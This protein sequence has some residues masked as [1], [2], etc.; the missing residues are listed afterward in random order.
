VRRNASLDPQASPASARSKILVIKPSALG[1]V[2]QALPV[3][4]SLRRN[5]PE[6][7]IDWV[8]ND[9]YADLLRGHPAIRRLVLYPRSRWT[10][11]AAL[12]EMRR[13][14]QSLAFE[15]YD[16]VIDLQGLLRSGLMA[17]ASGC[18][19]RLGLQSAREGSRW[20]YTES[21]QDHQEHAAE[22]YLQAIRH[23]GLEPHPLAFDLPVPPLPADPRLQPK[24]YVVL[25]PYSRWTTKLWPYRRYQE[26]VDQWP[27]VTLAVVGNGPW[28]PLRSPQVV[29]LRGLLGLREL[30]SVLAH[31]RAAISTDSGPAH[32][33]AAFDV[34]TVVLFGATDPRKTR[35][36][37]RRVHALQAEVV[38]PCL[39]CLRRAC[40]WDHPMACM[41]L[42]QPD[43][44][45]KLIL[46]LESRM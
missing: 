15:G 7:E 25:H 39:P 28:F 1:D 41:E 3:A 22:R 42:I 12:P 36:Q 10:S 31:A 9:S 8:I 19:R 40:R 11:L 24:A 35:P 20:F 33:A 2:V 17:W 21:I 5:W 46:Y 23:L 37:G 45:K 29:D 13:W 43:A 6:A 34:P 4:G 32:L 27:S 16:L 14:A 18:P 38:P 30:S 44:I 26:L